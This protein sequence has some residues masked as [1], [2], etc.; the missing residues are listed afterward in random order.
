MYGTP[1]V[2]QAALQE[3]RE[4]V[5]RGASLE[6]AVRRWDCVETTEMPC[7]IMTVTDVSPELARRENS[8]HD[9]VGNR[10]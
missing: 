5:A 8:E 3:P 9:H 1:R 10:T 7:L 6:Q 2:A 4:N